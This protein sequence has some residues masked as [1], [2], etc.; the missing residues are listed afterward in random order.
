MLSA[1]GGADEKLETEPAGAP[2]KTAFVN[3]ASAVE[4]VWT[5]PAARPPVGT[6]TAAAAL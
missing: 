5:V 1:D 6:G 4:T 2:A 3:A